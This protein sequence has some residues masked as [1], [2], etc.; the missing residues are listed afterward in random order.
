LE[1]ATEMALGRGRF[2]KTDHATRVKAIQW[3]VARG[4]GEEAIVVELEIDRK[5]EI[6]NHRYQRR[7]CLT[8]QAAL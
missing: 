8:E 7:G 3:V 4:C 6:K 1:L 5:I 2:T